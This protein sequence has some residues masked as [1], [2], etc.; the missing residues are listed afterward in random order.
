MDKSPHN[1][2]NIVAMSDFQPETG[3][4]AI[5]QVEA[6]WDAIRGNRVVPRRSDIDPRG[7]EQALENAFILER[8]A[9]GV[10]R[11]RLAG[12]HLNELIG[13]E[14]RGMP[15]TA[16]FT[17]AARAG[18]S[19]LLEEVFQSP[20]TAVLSLTGTKAIGRPALDA[21]LLL[22][23]LKSD[24]GDV[25]RVLGCWVSKG[26][27]GSTPRRFDITAK[28]LTRL[29]AD[30]T[31]PTELPV[32]PRPAAPASKT[33]APKTHSNEG[34]AE[35]QTPFKSKDVKRRPPYLRLIDTDDS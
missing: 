29:V 14:A 30:P 35:D 23:P 17:P 1:P 6:Y 5:S 24:L 8:I 12:N 9:P 11:I 13:M 7:I 31:R 3:Y 19:E 21:R 25:S 32:A 26:S 22:L 15:L 34:M 28:T 16:F 4:T 10:A 20:A 18:F 27:I 33:D 2:Q